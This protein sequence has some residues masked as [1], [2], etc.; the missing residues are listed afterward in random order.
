MKTIINN[1]KKYMLISFV[2]ISAGTMAADN[3][4]YPLAPELNHIELP[5]VF[6]D[7]LASNPTETALEMEEWMYDASYWNNTWIAEAGDSEIVLEN[8]MADAS[9]WNYS[10]IT[11]ADDSEV[12]LENW[13]ADPDLWKFSR[14]HDCA[15]LN[16]T[17]V[18]ENMMSLDDWMKDPERWTTGS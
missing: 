7:I 6:V 14:N 3:G 1:L 5:S 12:V 18:R 2:F 10:W 15:E 8:W 17:D 13:M 16:E 9:Y 11:E 4:G